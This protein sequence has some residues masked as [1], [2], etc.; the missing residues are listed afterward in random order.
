MID[1]AISYA[2]GEENRYSLP[3]IPD[4]IQL[5]LY[6]YDL[7]IKYK[8]ELWKEICD[9]NVNVRTI[10]LPID[11]LTRDFKDTYQ[12]MIDGLMDF[13]CTHYIVHPNKFIQDY[14][15]GF[16]KL[17]LNV[18]LCIENF[19]WRAKK[20]YRT[21]L[22]IIERILEQDEDGGRQNLSMTLD[23]S[24]TDTVWFDYHIMPFILKYASVIHL[25]NRAKDHGNHMPFNSSKGELNLVTFVND[26]KKYGWEGIIVLEYLYKYQDKLFKNYHYLKRLVS[27]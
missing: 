10:H 26:L 19:Q 22:N 3:K 1:V 16:L 8:D 18:K 24:H 4:S 25:S 12:I 13:G 11:S 27:Q 15:D 2:I 20:V 14:I 9:N 5:A 6:K 21:P 17:N 23:T 7:Y